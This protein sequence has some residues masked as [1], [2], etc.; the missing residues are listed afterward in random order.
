MYRLTANQAIEHAWQRTDQPVASG[1]ASRT[2]MWGPQPLGPALTEPYSSTPGGFRTVQYFDKSRMEITQPGADASADWYVT[3]GLLARDLILGLDQVGDNEF[4]SHVPANI[5]VAGDPDDSAG[6]TYASFIELLYAP[7]IAD[8]AVIT[9]RID[10]AGQVTN[11]P[12]LA[13]RGVTAGYHVNVP[14]ID[15]QVASP[16]WE[17]MNSSAVVYHRWRVFAATTLQQ[18]VLRHRLPNYR[19][20]LGAC[21]R[22][23]HASRTC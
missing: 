1:A 15:H 21:Y 13:S 14:N 7:P 22:G 20:V 9:Q 10:R 3:N 8:G 19:G 5:N 17:F 4:D 18:S 2:W 6:P 16:F 23:R 12:A 11:D